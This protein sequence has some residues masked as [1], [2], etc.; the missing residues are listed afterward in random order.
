M[1]LFPIEEF[2][3]LSFYITCD[4]EQGEGEEMESGTPPPVAAPAESEAVTDGGRTASGSGGDADIPV[5]PSLKDSDTSKLY[6]LA[7]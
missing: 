5:V 4:T 7:V 3:S 6:K 2:S 1:R